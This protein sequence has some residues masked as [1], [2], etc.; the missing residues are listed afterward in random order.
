[1]NHSVK[2]KWL[3]IDIGGTKCSVSIGETDGEKPVIIEKTSF[4]T[5]TSQQDALD[6]I[7]DVAMQFTVKHNPVSAGI[8]AGGPMDSTCG[9]FLN[10]PNLPGWNHLSWTGV[11]SER[12]H[13]PAALE[14][15]ANACALAEF[16]WGAGAGCSSM[17]FLT[18]GTGLGAGLILNGKLFRGACGNAGEVGHWRLSNN[19]PS[20]YGKI[21]SFEGF[22]SGGGIRQIA[23]LVSIRER[24]KGSP[25]SFEQKDFSAKTIAE[26]ARSGD[27]N[28]QEI[29][30]LSGE[31]LG[32]G[33]SLMIDLLNPERIIIGSIYARCEDLL[34]DP[35]EQVLRKECLPFSLDHCSILPAGLGENVGD[36]AAFAIAA[37]IQGGSL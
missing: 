22:C 19:G 25:V 17:V 10:P 34:K 8:S 27:S 14:N 26:A 2:V 4:P 6:F 7:C 5:P 31:M 37:G 11:L 13:I 24:Q 18:F 1:M 35:M 20:G 16:Y 36:Y 29:M 32:R 30:R 21:G 12:L 23:E 33:L 3:G 9:V 28:A 15:D